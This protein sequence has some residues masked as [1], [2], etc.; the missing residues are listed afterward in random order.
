MTV[1][2]EAEGLAVGFEGRAVVEHIR[3]RL[4]LGAV[5]AILGTNGSGKTTFLRTVMGLQPVMSGELRVL[6][7][8]PA[9]Q[10]RRVAYVGQFHPQAFTLPLRVRD[11]V[12]MGR[13]PHLGLMGRPSALDREAVEEAMGRMDVADLARRPL[14]DL[15]GGQRQR[16]FLARALAQRGDLLVLDEPTGGLDP[17]ARELLARAITEERDR[18]AAVVHSTH[19]V[20]EAMAADLAMLVAGRLVSVGPPAQA[21]S[22]DAL[23]AAFGVVV[24]DLPD[25]TPVVLDDGHGHD[26]S[27]A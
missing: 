11:V 22:R 14:R 15:S 18:G 16:V 26:H 27:H 3:L 10:P 8:A 17:A 13:I 12:A 21:V 9:G 7:G 24:Q 20:R 2:L 19:D 23:M 5:L 4:P 6:G 1:A 25:G